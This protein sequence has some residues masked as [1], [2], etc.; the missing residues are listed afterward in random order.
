MKNDLGPVHQRLKNK[1]QPSLQ[2]RLLTRIHSYC[3]RRHF[4]FIRLKGA[5]CSALPPTSEV[6]SRTL[7]LHDQ[8]VSQATLRL[9]SVRTPSYGLVPV[10]SL[11]L[12]CEVISAA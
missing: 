11:L 8:G 12:V 5:D 2:R 6:P 3:F 10:P 1:K 7:V 9:Q 4:A